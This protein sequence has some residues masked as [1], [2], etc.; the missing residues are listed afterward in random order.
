[1]TDHN[2]KH[3]ELPPVIKFTVKGRDETAKNMYLLMRRLA[4]VHRTELWTEVSNALRDSILY[5]SY[6]GKGF[7]WGLK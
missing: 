2:Q 3:K 1:M 5:G 6:V 7:D 4:R